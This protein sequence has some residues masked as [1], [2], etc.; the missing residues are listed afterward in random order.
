MAAMQWSNSL[1]K[2]RAIGEQCV[3]AERKFTF[4]LGVVLVVWKCIDLFV[5]ELFV[6]L[7]RW[8]AF[9]LRRAR[10][11][12]DVVT[13]FY[14]FFIC[15][16][17][18]NKVFWIIWDLALKRTRTENR[19][20]F[21]VWSNGTENVIYYESQHVV[22]MITWKNGGKWGSALFL[23]APSWPKRVFWLLETHAEN[24][25]IRSNV[26][27]NVMFTFKESDLLLFFL[28]WRPNQSAA[29]WFWA[30]TTNNDTNCCLEK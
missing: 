28:C 4:G 21:S 19:H 13:I 22:I 14:F 17:K 6:L 27:L 3:C 2:S 20:A 5:M 25:L 16:K 15:E 9:V 7:N 11:V 23:S 8:G 26:T 24:Q 18:K 1:L 29:E 12:C 30:L 10:V